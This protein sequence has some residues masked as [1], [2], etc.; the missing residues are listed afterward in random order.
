MLCSV[1]HTP[2]TMVIDCGTTTWLKIFSF[3]Y[4]VNG[5]SFFITYV[6]TKIRLYDGEKSRR[7]VVSSHYY[8]YNE[9]NK[10]ILE[11]EKHWKMVLNRR[12]PKSPTI[13]SISSKT[14]HNLVQEF[15]VVCV[16]T[17]WDTC[18]FHICL[19]CIC[20]EKVGLWYKKSTLTRFFY[21]GS[22]RNRLVL[23]TQ[24]G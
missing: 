20:L 18:V 13:A 16:S 4:Y 9:T 5:S 15:I 10:E 3:R 24:N 17:N 19:P 14:T 6:L 23:K 21:G 2:T 1:V 22:V 7:R 12:L 11:E 8:N